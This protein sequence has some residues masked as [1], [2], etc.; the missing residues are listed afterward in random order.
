MFY[1][2][3]L[4]SSKY[5]LIAFKGYYCINWFIK[6]PITSG[7]ISFFRNNAYANHYYFTPCEFFKSTLNKWVF[8]GVCE[9]VERAEAELEIF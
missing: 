9:R 7:I 5:I 2:P 8:S 6:L 1:I 4:N 3:F